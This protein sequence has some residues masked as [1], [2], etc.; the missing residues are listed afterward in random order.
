MTPAAPPRLLRAV[1]ER[2]L[3][4]TRPLR[5]PW[6]RALVLV[7][8]AAAVVAGIPLLHA[9]RGDMDAIGFVHAW[10]FSIAQAYYDAGRL[11][12]ANRMYTL[13]QKYATDLPAAEEA[14]GAIAIVQGRADDAAWYLRKAVREA[15]RSLFTRRAAIAPG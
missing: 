4:P 3:K 9:F 11:A 15:P 1:V 7:P 5:R 13:L 14:L 6:A 10:G 2:D 8:I 12:D